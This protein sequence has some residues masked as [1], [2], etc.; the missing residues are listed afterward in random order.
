MDPSGLL[1][2]QSSYLKYII[3][4]NCTRELELHFANY[5]QESIVSPFG[6]L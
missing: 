4:R 3:F 5:E 2:K 1:H 6:A